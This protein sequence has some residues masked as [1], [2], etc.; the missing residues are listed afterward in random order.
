VVRR[1]RRAHARAQA[2]HRHGRPLRL[3]LSAR[4]CICMPPASSILVWMFC[5]CFYVLVELDAYN[6]GALLCYFWWPK[7]VESCGNAWTGGPVF[8]VLAGDLA[9][10]CA[11][12]F[13][14]CMSP[15]GE[16]DWTNL[17]KL[18]KMCTGERYLSAAWSFVGVLCCNVG[19]SAFGTWA[20]VLL[21]FEYIF[22]IFW[23]IWS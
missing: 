20:L 5:I 3:A 18:N 1:L 12:V 21:F 13:F 23:K 8:M 17:K 7:S 14:K 15:A 4:L 16:L 19:K 22:L 11:H 10:S 9:H 6:G 2:V